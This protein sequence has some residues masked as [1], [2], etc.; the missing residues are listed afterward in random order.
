M[1]SYRHL[2]RT[3]VMQTLFAVEFKKS[4][5]E[6]DA[7]KILDK[8]LDEFA[9]K[10]TEKE[11]AHE[12]LDGLLQHKNEIFNLIQ[13]YAPQWPVDKI[14]KVDRAI[15]EIGTYEIVFSKDV[16]PVVAINEAIEMAK[17]FGDENSSKFVNGVLSSIMKNHNK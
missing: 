15:L 1:A 3:C 4:G 9:P 10:L 7:K 5:V 12:T 11:F 6:V 2:A 13:K 8:I 17:Q 16:P 14:A